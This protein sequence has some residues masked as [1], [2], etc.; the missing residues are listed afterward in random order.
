MRTKTLALAAFLASVLFSACAAPAPPSPAATGTAD[1]E[2]ALRGLGDRYVA[3]FNAGDVAGLTGL[4]ADDYECVLPDGT[5]IT[6][7]AAFQQMFE[8]DVAARQ[9]AG[10]T[11]ALSATTAMLKWIDSTNAV[12]GGTWTITGVPAGAPTSGSWMSVTSKGTDSQWRIRSS[13]AADLMPQ[14]GGGN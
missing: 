8:K 5:H 9:E 2:A 10:L 11:L 6:G 1:D 14:P 3:A 7:R 13:L 12:I 4:V